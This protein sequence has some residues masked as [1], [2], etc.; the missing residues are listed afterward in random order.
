MTYV[1]VIRAAT[2]ADSADLFSWRND[3]QTRAASISQDLVTWEHHTAWM[4]RSLADDNRALYIADAG[5][6]ESDKSPMGMCRF[7]LGGGV[8]EVSINLSPEY[9]GMGLAGPVLHA[10]IAQ[11]RQDY[12]D[13]VRLTATVRSGNLAS[14]KIFTNE[15]FTLASVDPQFLY[16]ECD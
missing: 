3:E 2:L 10:A 6:A 11:F 16:Y 14:S 7:D 5:D 9:R 15:G 4:T 1:I 8:A 12:G 13:T